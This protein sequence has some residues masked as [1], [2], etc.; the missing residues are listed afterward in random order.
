MS[1]PYN[2]SGV[3]QP[4]GQQPGGQQPGG[5]QPGGGS[6]G[7]QPGQQNFG[8]PS[9]PNPQQGGGTY[10]A[11]GSYGQSPAG[12][13]GYDSSNA[14]YPSPSSFTAGGQQSG[15]NQGGSFSA[16]NF[17]NQVA[18]DTSNKALRGVGGALIVLGVFCALRNIINSLDLLEYGVP[19]LT[20][21]FW[22]NRPIHAIQAYGSILLPIIGIVLMV[23]ASR[24]K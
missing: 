15:Y 5:Q 7:T 24:K 9:Q 2:P 16:S 18:S 4:G 11:P 10:G 8:Q 1:N 20:A 12:A 17:A 22:V 14:G 23:V 6:Y 3:N 13:Q 21:Y 19:F